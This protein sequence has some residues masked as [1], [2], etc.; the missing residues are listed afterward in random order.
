MSIKPTAALDLV[1]EYR[2]RT[3]VFWTRALPF[4]TQ[5]DGNVAIVKPPIL[6]ASNIGFGT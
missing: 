5:P 2:Y 4:S 3:F 6:G 1:V